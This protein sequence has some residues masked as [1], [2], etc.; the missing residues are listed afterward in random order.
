MGE[1]W[2]EGKIGTFSGDLIIAPVALGLIVFAESI[3]TAGRILDSGVAALDNFG[4]GLK[5]KS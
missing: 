5:K 2:N 3:E 1:H 4:Q